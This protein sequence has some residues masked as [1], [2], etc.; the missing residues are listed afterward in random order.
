MGFVLFTELHQHQIAG[1]LSGYDRL[2]FQG[3]LPGLCFAGGMSAYLGRQGVRVMDY[4]RWAEPLRDQLRHNAERLAA[5]NALTIEHIRRTKSFR[6]EAKVKEILATRGEHP[7]LVWIFS[8]MEPCDSYKPWYDK[9]T[10]HVSLKPDSG[11]CLHYYFYFIDE[12]LGLC[13]ARVPTWCPFRLQIYTNGRNWLAAEMRKRGMAFRQLDNAFIEIADWAVAQDLA[14]RFRVKHL[15]RKLDEFA[16]RFCPVIQPLGMNYHWS[17]NQ[18]EYATDVVFRRQS[19][20]QAIYEPLTR[21]AVQ[22][23]KADQVATFLGRKLFAHYQDEVGNR[24]D[25]RIQGTRIKHTMGPVSI[26]MYDKLG[27]ILRIETTVNDVTFFPHYREVEQRDGQRVRK[28]AEMKR[29]IYSLPVLSERLLAANRRY[30]E[31]LSTLEDPT[32]GMDKLDRFTQTIRHKERGYPG[33]NFFR[34]EDR[35]LM[36]TLVRGEYNIQG[37]RNKDLRQHLKG[38]SPGQVSRLLKRLRLHGVLRKAG[39][40]YRYLLTPLGKQLITLALKLRTFV[41]VPE[42]AAAS[43]T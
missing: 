39:S 29:N 35:A 21:V 43:A 17:I 5:E 27:L 11:K 12:Q 37:L 14:D 20:L 10:H 26:K 42:L 36:E 9:A 30:L 15:H 13:F 7:G 6:K 4:P 1:V 16:R 24:F 18:A 22:A 33:F 38:R 31:F 23:I 40:A 41:L 2:L 25:V 32:A 3:T 28:W 19:D 8:A 34:T